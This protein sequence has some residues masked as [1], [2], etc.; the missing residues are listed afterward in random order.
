MEGSY[1][2]RQVPRAIFRK[3]DRSFISTSARFGIPATVHLAAAGWVGNSC[4]VVRTPSA[5]RASLRGELSSAERPG[6]GHHPAPGSARGQSTVDDED[7]SHHEPGFGGGEGEKR[8]RRGPRPDRP[9]PW[10]RSPS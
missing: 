6:L 3:D 5:Q 7:L 10:E 2:V 9:L 4:P 8:G 1:A